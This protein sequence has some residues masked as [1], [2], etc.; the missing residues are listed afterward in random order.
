[1]RVARGLL[2]GYLAQE[3]CDEIPQHGKECG[4]EKLFLTNKL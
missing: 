2:E 4:L 3:S 1:M